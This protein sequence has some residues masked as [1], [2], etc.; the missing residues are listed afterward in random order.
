[1][2]TKQ[3]GNVSIGPIYTKPFKYLLD[4]NLEL[5]GLLFKNLNLDLEL[6]MTSKFLD[7][8]EGNDLREKFNSGKPTGMHTP[9]S[10]VFNYK[11]G[12]TPGLSALDLVFNTGP[13]ASSYLRSEAQN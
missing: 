3:I 10:Q 6:S 2:P 9:Y 5:T 13:Q 1:L 8:Y 4:L 7:Q 11:Y 12:F